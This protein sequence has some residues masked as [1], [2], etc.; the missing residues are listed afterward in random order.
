MT[1]RW[2]IE[3]DQGV[4]IGSGLCAGE[5]PAAFRLGAARRSEPVTAEVA[6]SER[7]LDV[8]ESCPV[9]AISIRLARDGEAVFPPA[10]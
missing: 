9:E 10:E 6:A 7:V 8:A 5:A 2:R 3:V 1:E 4:C